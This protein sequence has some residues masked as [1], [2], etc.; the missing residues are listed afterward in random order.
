[1]S[2]YL[3]VRYT[4]G[5]LSRTIKVSNSV[6]AQAQADFASLSGGPNLV[7]QYDVQ[8]YLVSHIPITGQVSINWVTVAVLANFDEA[9]AGIV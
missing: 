9:P 2:K 8:D 3:K 1:M 7:K 6:A 4:S 5:V